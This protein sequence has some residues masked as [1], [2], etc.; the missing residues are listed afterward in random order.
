MGSTSSAN[1]H[2]E[3]ALADLVRQ[4]A[5]NS[6]QLQDMSPDELQRLASMVVLT[7]LKNDL[8]RMADLAKIDCEVEVQSFL[9][10]ASR[11]GSWPTIVAYTH[12]LA[13]LDEWVFRNG[14]DLLTLSPKLADEYIYSLRNA[15]RSPGTIR[16]DVAGPSAF[17]AFLERRYEVIRNPFRGSRARPIYRP[18]REIVIPTADELDVILRSAR[19]LVRAAIMCMS[20]RGLR[21]GALPTLSFEREFYSGWSKG[22]GVF[23]QMPDVAMKAI[24]AAGL[25]NHRPFSGLSSRWIA[26]AVRLHAARLAKKGLVRETF[27]AHDYR[28]YFAVS[29]YQRN[30]DLY[31]VKELLG[32]S[33][34]TTTECYLRALKVL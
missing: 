15:G 28:H 4:L 3:E 34:A 12:S 27:S 11:S 26:E 17:F 31:R 9:S 16:L 22:K 13:R 30:R 5:T 14:Y 29:D 7:N 25:G 23:G 8:K 2:R 24:A 21:V 33:Y 19:P 20:Q 6:P 32:H 18:T 10:T 1:P